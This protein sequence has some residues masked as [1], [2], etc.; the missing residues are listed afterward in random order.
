MAA[1]YASVTG[2]ASRTDASRRGHRNIGGH[3]RGWN[4]GVE[5]HGYLDS[6]G[7]ER[8]EVYLTGGS[9]G[10]GSRDHLGTAYIGAGGPTFIYSQNEAPID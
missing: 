5:V 7:H 2:D 3:V 8:F 10:A 1:L 9:N 4:C 6:D